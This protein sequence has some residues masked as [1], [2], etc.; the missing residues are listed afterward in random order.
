MP[1]DLYHAFMDRGFRRSG[2]LIYQPV[3]EGCRECVQLRVPVERFTPS[4]SQRR[5]WRKNSDITAVAGVPEASKEKFELYRRYVN[6]RHAETEIGDY[7]DFVRFLYD[8]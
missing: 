4:K 6:A 7:L 3:C 2:K 5:V 8:S 1:G